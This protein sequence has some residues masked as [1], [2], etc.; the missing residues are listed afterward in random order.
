MLFAT[1]SHQCPT[2]Y[3]M[4]VSRRKRLLARAEADN[5]LIVEDDYEF[6][7]TFT[8]APSPSLKSLDD[9]GRV[10]YVGSFSKSLFPGLR[11]GFLVAPVA[12]VQE[13]RKLRSTI[14]RHPPGLIQRTAAYFLSLGHYD[15]QINRMR[16]A[17]QRRRQVMSDAIRANGLVVSGEMDA[18]GSSF[19]MQAPEGLNTEDL[20]ARLHARG[21]VLEPG[22]AFFDPDRART[23]FY[24]LAYS[25]ISSARIP[26]GIEMIAEEIAAT[27]PTS[28]R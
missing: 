20:A 10:I 16:K 9:A 12:F 7:L 23:D 14:L 13:A 17:Y 6:E 2:N 15:A 11:L 5:F 4:P 3:T 18:G 8:Q 25:S 1:V 24:R 22:S 28:A 27:G 26:R 21:V 19:W